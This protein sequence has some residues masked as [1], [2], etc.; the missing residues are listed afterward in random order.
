[1]AGLG[2]IG[3]QPRRDR[4]PLS[5]ESSRRAS[6]MTLWAVDD[7]L[8]TLQSASYRIAKGS[9]ELVALKPNVIVVAGGRAIDAVRQATDIIP[10]VVPFTSD[11]LGQGFVTSLARSEGNIT[12]ES[13]AEVQAAREVDM[14]TC[15][16]C[17]GDGVIEKGT[18]D[19][20]QCPMCGGSG[21]V[22]DD[23]D[24]KNNEEVT[25]T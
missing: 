20:K 24:D 6:D 5:R 4:Q 13:F 11:L 2:T 16:E 15:P 17:N 21:F 23:N 8:L 10:V 3:K 18:D 12:G 14:K 9:A 25:R 22:P 1:M 19:E 7:P